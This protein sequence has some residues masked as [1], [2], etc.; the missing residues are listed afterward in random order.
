MSDLMLH[1]VLNMPLSDDP[2]ELD[3]LTWVQFR[4]RARQASAEIT[5]LTSALAA[6]EEARRAE[7]AAVV[8]EIRK[9]IFDFIANDVLPC[10]DIDPDLWIHDP[11]AGDSVAA[12]L[13]FLA[14]DDDNTA[15]E[16]VLKAVRT[17]K[18][19]EW[20]KL[21]ESSYRAKAPFFGHFRV[22]SYGGDTFDALWSVPGLVDTLINGAAFPNAMSAMAAVDELF[23]AGILSALSDTTDKGER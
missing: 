2:A 11:E 18:P 5:R 20:E 9:P 10:Y 15:L 8:R 3:L 22:D 23:A 14:T 7:R 16:R 19:L 6:S 1:G 4:D 13:E 17:V 21:S 12:F